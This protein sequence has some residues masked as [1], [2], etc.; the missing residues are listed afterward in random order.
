[1]RKKVNYSLMT[2][3]YCFADLLS[4][5]QTE[6]DTQQDVIT[7]LCLQLKDKHINDSKDKLN[8]KIQLNL[9]YISN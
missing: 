1:M 2:L 7:T 5:K 8:G 4:D 6:I 9:L 3:Q